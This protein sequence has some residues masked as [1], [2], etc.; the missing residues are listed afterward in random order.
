MA[1]QPIEYELSPS[2]TGVQ[3]VPAFSVFQTPP[4]AT[5]TN[6]R[7]GFVGSTAMSTMRPEVRAGPIDRKARPDQVS[8]DQPPFFSA[9]SSSLA[10]GFLSL[11]P[12]FASVFAVAFG[13][14][15]DFSWAVS[16]PAEAI[17]IRARRAAAFT[18]LSNPLNMRGQT[19]ELY[20][21]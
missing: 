4:E 9:L 13:G 21:A 18:V 15:G 3:V 5:A 19:G 14:A 7:C 8:A 11:A 2:K 10:A 20:E 17:A 6:Q 1:T 12:A 16:R